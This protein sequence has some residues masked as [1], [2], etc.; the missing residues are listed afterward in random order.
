LQ[1][2]GKCGT[3]CSEIKRLAGKRQTEMLHKCPMFLM[4]RKDMLL[5]LLLLLLYIDLI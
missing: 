2:A 4:G 1:E 5:L 3:A